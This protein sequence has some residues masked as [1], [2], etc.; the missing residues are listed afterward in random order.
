MPNTNYQFRVI[1][2]NQYGTFTGDYSSFK[3][4]DDTPSIS[5]SATKSGDNEVLINAEVI[6]SPNDTNITRVYLEYFNPETSVTS[7]ELDPNT[8]TYN[9]NINDLTQGPGYTFRLVVINTYNTFNKEAYFTLPVTYEIGDI[10]FGGIIVD[11]D[12][13]GYHGI[14]MA[15][16]SYSTDLQWS[17]DYHYFNS[18]VDQDRNG[19]E[20]S[21][22]VLDYYSNVSES[23]PAF[24]YCD[25]IVIEGYNDWYLPAYLEVVLASRLVNLTTGGTEI[26]TSTEAP[27]E[28][29]AYKLISM[30]TI[31]PADKQ[32][33]EKVIPFREF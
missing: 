31:Q 19:K 21:Q 14:V 1:L 10:K 20:N 13:T 26:W 2:T 8:L 25:N 27:M 24:E 30:A 18:Y 29:R 11:I 28:E 6:P 7:V 3:T 9:F 22:M 32:S 12:E 4:L 33:V 23:A 5:I 16:M 15:D 17:S